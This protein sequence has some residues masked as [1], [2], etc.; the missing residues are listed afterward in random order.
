[1]EG[2]KCIL[3]SICSLGIMFLVGG[4]CM[5][6]LTIETKKTTLNN[7]DVVTNNQLTTLS[8]NKGNDTTQIKNKM[9]VDTTEATKA[10]ATKQAQRSKEARRI[11]GRR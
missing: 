5:L 3:N 11:N 1:M 7:N 8:T 4:C 9:V 2:K 6:F 10:E